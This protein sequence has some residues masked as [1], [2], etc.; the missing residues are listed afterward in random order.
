MIR[1]SDDDHVSVL[2]CKL[3]DTGKDLVQYIAP[4]LLDHLEMGQRVLEKNLA[5]GKIK[6]QEDYQHSYQEV[7]VFV[8]LETVLLHQLFLLCA[9]GDLL[10]GELSFVIVFCSVLKGLVMVGAV[11][12]RILF[13]LGYL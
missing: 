12:N 5:R 8:S 1:C 3:A 6:D 10:F 11:A 13:L 7:K 2:V 9:L 4:I